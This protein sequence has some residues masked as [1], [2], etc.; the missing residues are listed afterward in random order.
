MQGLA[1]Q[2]S[3]AGPRCPRDASDLAEAAAPR[4]A[5]GPGLVTRSQPR[6]GL[7]PGLMAG[8]RHL[9][10]LG[11]G[12]GFV[13]GPLAGRCKRGRTSCRVTFLRERDCGFHS[14]WGGEE[15]DASCCFR[16]GGLAAA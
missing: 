16:D 9:G 15:R 4:E 5:Q 13:L 14:E 7:R 6:V 1:V 11:L 8:P 3:I 12:G 2:G 10:R